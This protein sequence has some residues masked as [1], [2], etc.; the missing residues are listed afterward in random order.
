[1][2][3]STTS[4]RPYEWVTLAVFGAAASSIFWAYD[5][6][7][8]MDLPAHAGLIA[9]RRRLAHSSYE[10]QWYVL[11]PHIGSYSLFRGAG[12]ALA[13]AVGPIGA[14]R[15]L[16]TLSVIALPVAILD[17]RRRLYG[18]VTPE[19]A[20][21]GLILGFG[22]MTLFGF[23]TF[24]LGVSFLV[25]CLSQWLELLSAELPAAPAKGALRDWLRRGLPVVLCT[26]VLFVTHGYA[27]VVFLACAGVTWLQAVVR[28]RGMADISA[29]DASRRYNPAVA[30]VALAPAVALAAYSAWVERQ[31]HPPAEAA[32]RP[33]TESAL[34]FQPLWDKLSL[35]ITP[36]L[37]TRT[38]LDIVV[39]VVVWAVAVASVGAA[40]AW[41]RH[42]GSGQAAES[43]R[44]R[45]HARALLACLILLAVAFTALPHEIS[46]FGFVDG[47]LVLVWLVLACLCVP[48]SAIGP[49]LSVAYRRAIPSLCG[50]VVA[51]LLVSSYR[52]QREAYGYREVLSAVPVE[53]NLLNLPIDPNSDV[54][55]GH[56]FI[57]YDKLVLA[58]RPVLVSDLWFHQG[59]AIYPRP[60]NPVLRLPADYHP[61]NL[62]AIDW[63]RFDL[64]VWNYV[65]MRTRPSASSPATPSSLRLVKHVGGWW[66]YTTGSDGAHVLPG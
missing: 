57:H 60:G 7:P 1:M 38:G 43:R 58:E 65:L 22:L 16:A 66:L 39:G 9:L 61:S 54:F 45:H 26:I 20:F 56:P 53:A 17:G 37:M 29:S 12:N 34:L 50:C 59:S 4:A 24:M 8:F 42:G 18:R 47:R 33:P 51:L 64:S 15:L 48:P 6:M 63:N 49:R 36:T 44:S 55:T 41:L 35:L 28:L 31:E 23:A 14:V 46:W 13:G 25:L 27:F 21:L 10:Q 62:G 3:E 5:A 40:V 32:A 52:F 2:N 19:F 11:A 30:V